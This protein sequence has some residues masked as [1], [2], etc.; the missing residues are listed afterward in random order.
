MVNNKS[1]KDNS[2]KTRQRGESITEG[3]GHTLFWDKEGNPTPLSD[4]FKK[5][6]NRIEEE[7]EWIE[8]MQDANSEDIQIVSLGESDGSQFKDPKSDK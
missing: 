3:L 4:K 6:L 2:P 8:G 7:Q 1:R 5:D